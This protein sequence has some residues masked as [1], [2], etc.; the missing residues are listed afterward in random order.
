MAQSNEIRTCE[1][2]ERNYDI[3]EQCCPLCGVPNPM[4]VR[5]D[6]IHVD[7][8]M[9]LGLWRAILRECG[10]RDPGLFIKEAI[11]WFISRDKGK[12]RG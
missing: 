4:F 7:V 6:E 5:P 2:C 3:S 8:K 11:E 1:L 12:K 10:S 9:E